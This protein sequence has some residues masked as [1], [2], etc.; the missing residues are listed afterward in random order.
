V[1]WND[2]HTGWNTGNGRW[3]RRRLHEYTA[4]QL[5]ACLKIN[6][7][8]C[9]ESRRGKQDLK[10]DCVDI[11]F[12]WYFLER[13]SQNP[14][15]NKSRLCSEVKEFSTLGYCIRWTR[16]VAK[17]RAA[18]FAIHVVRIQRQRRESWSSARRD[19][20]IACG[21]TFYTLFNFN[22]GRG[23]NR[24]WRFSLFLLLSS[25]LSRLLRNLRRLISKA[26]QTRGSSMILDPIKAI[27][28]TQAAAQL[29]QD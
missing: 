29:A 17:A 16:I 2:R 11:S 12:K 3:R 4:C 9:R 27:D 14:I 8:L 20:P 7:N 22:N 10:R 15:Q 24:L 6:V 26:G 25:K 23:V 5:I 21:Q 13:R 28:A 19:A 1:K 18:T